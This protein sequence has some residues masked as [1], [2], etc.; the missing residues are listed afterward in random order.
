M[1]AKRFLVRFKLPQMTMQPVIAESAR[2]QGDQ[3]VFLDSKRKQVAVF[4]LTVVE[5]WSESDL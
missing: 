2:I 5:S 1:A 3:L 4:V